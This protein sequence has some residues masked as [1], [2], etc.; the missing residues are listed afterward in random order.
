MRDTP[1]LITV[2]VTHIRT[3]FPFYYYKPTREVYP[4]SNGA[5][6]VDPGVRMGSFRA[7]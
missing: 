4:A 2:F 1:R 7:F 5:E 6:H 3:C